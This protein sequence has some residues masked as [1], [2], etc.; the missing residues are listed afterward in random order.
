MNRNDDSL[1][2]RCRR[3][4]KALFPALKER[5]RLDG[6]ALLW[7]GSLARDIDLVACPWTEACVDQADLAEHLR[8]VA[9]AVTGC[10]FAAPHDNVPVKKPHGRLAWEFHFGGGPYI[11]LSVMP[12][13]RSDKQSFKIILPRPSAGETEEG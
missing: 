6:Y 8:K 13:A 1:A 7:H 2:Q 10:C 9:E 11:D 5:A 3:L 12:V 4:F